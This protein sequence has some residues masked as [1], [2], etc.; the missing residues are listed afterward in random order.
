MQWAA[1]A[2]FIIGVFA[3]IQ[4]RALH[5]DGIYRWKL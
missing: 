5:P 3:R 1:P 2:Q 4:V